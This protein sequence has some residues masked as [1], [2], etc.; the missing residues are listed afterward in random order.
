MV[1]QNELFESNLHSQGEKAVSELVNNYELILKELKPHKAIFVGVISVLPKE[2]VWP[3]FDA[4]VTSAN[5][6]IKTL[7][8]K[9]GATYLDAATP[10]LNYQGNRRDLY[11][12]NNTNELSETGYAILAGSLIERWDIGAAATDV[13]AP[14]LKVP[15]P[16]LVSD[17]PSV[18]ESVSGSASASAAAA[19]VRTAKATTVH[20]QRMAY[21]KAHPAPV[22]STMI[23][24]DSNTQLWEVYGKNT[25]YP[26]GLVNRG[27]GGDTSVDILQR[28]KIHLAE[29]PSR[30]YI[31]M[32]TN[33]IGMYYQYANQILTSN[34]AS[35]FKYMKLNT[36]SIEL[37]VVSIIPSYWENLVHNDSVIAANTLIKAQ[38]LKNKI[39]FIDAYSAIQAAS[40]PVDLYV[41]SAPIHLN[42]EGFKVFASALPQPIVKPFKPV[43]GPI[44]PTVEKIIIGP[45]P[46]PV[47]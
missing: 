46:R 40:S 21:F 47:L 39:Q 2:V 15:T 27:I 35:I 8:N 12:N 1:G 10:I 29:K 4:D 42:T 18:V 31:M 20:A 11:L 37:I 33:D 13:V 9:Y 25:S 16:I 14:D 22:G 28:I 32:G 7:C 3:A 34:Y 44:P 6:Q 43:I 23:I 41:Y 5:T 26:V 19:P 24:G 45:C 30:V 38:C 17:E 36:P